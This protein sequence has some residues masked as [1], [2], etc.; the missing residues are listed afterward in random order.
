MAI[1]HASFRPRIL[2]QYRVQRIETLFPHPAVERHPL[3]EDIKPV[4][5]ELAYPN[6]ADLA[7]LQN[8]AG[9]QYAQMLRDSGCLLYTSD[10]ADE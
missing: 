6:A 4:A 1:Q 3:R 2:L 8:S 10:A 9:L 7:R 5:I